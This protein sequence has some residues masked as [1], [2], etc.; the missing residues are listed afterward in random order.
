MR[1]LSL[2]FVV[3][4]APCVTMISPSSAEPY[5][6]HP[7]PG[8]GD[9]DAPF[10]PD[11]SY[12]SDVRSPS[13]FLGFQLG[14]RPIQHD[15][16][17]RYYRYL[18]EN[19]PHAHLVVMGH[20][21]EGRELVFLIV[22]SEENARN[23]VA[24]QERNE[25]L[26]DPRKMDGNVSEM[27]ESMPA[28]AWMAYGIHGDELSSS[29]AAVY[30][31]Y[32]L[33]AGED[34]ITEEI[35]NNVLTCIDPME[36]P[37]GRTRWLSQM[38]S[39]NGVVPS[40][41][42]RSMQHRGMWPYGRTNHYLFD[43]NRDWFALVHPESR[44]R[45]RGIL[46]WY[47][48]FMVDAHEM[49]PLN[50]Y[51][52]SPPRE[53]FNPFMITQIHKW[54]EIVAMDQAAAFDKYGWSYYTREWNEEFYPGY[55]SSWGIYVGAIGMLYE[56]A[57]VDGSQVKRK[58]GTIMAY[59]ETIHH[60]FISSMANL[61]TVAT[62]RKE[63]LQDYYDEKKN[64]IA[65]H[66]IGSSPK[67]GS[68][69]AFIFPPSENRGRLE[70]LAQTL[71][72]Q[73]IEVDVATESFKLG[74]LESSTGESVKNMNLPEG[75]LIVRVNQPMRALLQAI[76]TFD[77]RMSTKFLESQRKELRKYGRSRLYETTAWALPL[78]YN[79]ES[80]F[81]NGL[82]RVKTRPF[83][84]DEEI[85]P[86]GT[87]IGRSPK[88]GYAISNADDRCF[89]F[90]GRLY[91]RDIKVW[92]AKKPFDVDGQSFEAGSL[93]IR[94]RANSGLD[95]EDMIELA[96]SEGV[97]VYAVNTALGA[98]M[99]DLGGDEFAQLR[100]P[101]IG[102]VGGSSVSTYNF[103]VVWHLMD[104]RLR[105]KTSLLDVSAIARMDI[106]KYNVIVLPTSSS[107]KGL[108]GKSGIKKLKDWV[109]DG[110]TLVAFG[111][112]AAFLADSSVALG[113]V[114]LRRQVLKDMKKYESDLW[115]V[116]DAE[117]PE[118]DSLYV[119]EG[120]ELERDDNDDEKKSDFDAIE[121]ADKLAQTLRPRGVIMATDLDDSHWMAFGARSP[122]PVIMNTGYVYMSSGHR[123]E[124][125]ARF[126]DEKR[127]RLSGLLWP[128]ARERW[129]E[130]AYATREAV[131]NGQV[132]LFAGTPNFRAFFHGGERLL[133]NALMLGPGMGTRPPLDW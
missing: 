29:E 81:T 58:D 17:I 42:I 128:E 95:D 6:T 121:N 117:S 9:Y 14:A 106:R 41:D 47:P 74:K 55:G 116:R 38:T 27:I 77:I 108:L 24:I 82:G 123:V 126:T 26:A 60:Q 61:T 80:Y 11:G 2:V 21:Y 70:R 78:A 68:G 102:I 91:E 76:L 44:A 133:L 94:L 22:T 86:E 129:S 118:V 115:R 57:G 49:G 48:Q 33:V 8:L 69:A 23:L 54:W 124:V 51:L 119:W 85:A 1:I 52:F 18:D 111:S 45:C 120:V 103:G 36:N 31:A 40:T 56:Q 73:K 84:E 37:D 59:R 43:L 34:P 113:S 75:T 125:A 5:R 62:N 12:R 127:L 67:M 63:L 3:A 131:G 98:P 97:D 16:I 65:G 92:A 25:M 90:L 100:A 105:L 71:A 88:Y 87:L 132:I 93:V 101:R 114:R 19:F 83:S 50:T 32:Q 20:T 110:G 130:T 7:T 35:R 4:F 109:N 13:D 28:T 10:W 30:L 15:E 107:Y 46:R 72:M 39:W 53:P 96:R 104:S 112:G 122:M 89:G 66:A 64:A 79:V 99:A